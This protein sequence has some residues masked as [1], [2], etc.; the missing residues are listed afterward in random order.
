MLMVVLTK[1]CLR[2]S[3]MS[4]SSRGTSGG[5]GDALP[6]KW[7]W[8]GELD[9]IA[10]SPSNAYWGARELSSSFAILSFASRQSPAERRFMLSCGRNSFVKSA[11]LA[12]PLDIDTADSR[13]THLVQ[14]PMVLQPLM[15]KQFLRARSHRRV[16]VKTFLR[17]ATSGPENRSGIGGRPSSII[18]N[19]AVRSF[20]SATAEE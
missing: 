3:N 20:V 4:A 14:A 18:W 2:I 11:I 17:N 7:R 12:I 5:T 16:L 1:V 8:P 6:V 15:L 19:I 10:M 13:Q 9:N